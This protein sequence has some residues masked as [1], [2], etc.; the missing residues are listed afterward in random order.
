[1]NMAFHCVKVRLMA[2]CKNRT[3][4]LCFFLSRP[5]MLMKERSRAEFFVRP[6]SLVSLS[7]LYVSAIRHALPCI[8]PV[9]GGR[10]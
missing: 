5:L 7:V 4:F 9:S 3:R 8:A 2:F 1:M 10:W 6:T